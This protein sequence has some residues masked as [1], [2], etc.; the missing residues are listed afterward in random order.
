MKSI[1]LGGGRRL[2]GILDLLAFF[3]VSI[4]YISI[5]LDGGLKCI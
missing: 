2:G 4:V 1:S 3:S 5:S